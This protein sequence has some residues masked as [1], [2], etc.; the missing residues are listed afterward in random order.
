M[1]AWGAWIQ[2]PVKGRGDGRGGWGEGAVPRS[3][4]QPS[5]RR[6]PSVIGISMGWWCTAPI[7]NTLFY[8]VSQRLRNKRSYTHHTHHHHQKPKWCSPSG[9]SA[10][11]PAAVAVPPPQHRRGWCARCTGG[12]QSTEPGGTSQGQPL[13]TQAASPSPLGS[14]RDGKGRGG[15]EARRD[16]EPKCVSTTPHDVPA[17]CD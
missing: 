3:F 11:G 14:L 13:T 15:G 5:S 4:W 6:Q 2:S 10:P 7:P 12:C 8:P 9:F 1:L 16:R 17:C